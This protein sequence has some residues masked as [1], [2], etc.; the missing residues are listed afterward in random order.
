VTRHAG[1]PK[2]R[3]ETVEEDKP[4]VH[5]K[6]G[7]VPKVHLETVREDEPMKRA[8]GTVRGMV[9]GT[10]EVVKRRAREQPVSNQD[11]GR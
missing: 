4:M 10:R 7:T 11:P 5:A 9:V 6:N 1:A 8:D 3:V 2:I